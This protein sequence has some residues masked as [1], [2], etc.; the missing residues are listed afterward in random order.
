MKIIFKN[1]LATVESFLR[2]DATDIRTYQ[3]PDKD[4]TVAGI[5]DITKAQVGLDQVD[6]TSDINKPVS[7]AQQAAI[8]SAVVG[9]MDYRGVFDASVNAYP[10]SGGSG[11]AG[12]ILKSDFWIVSVLGTLPT[13][14]VVAPGD[15]IIAIVDTP[16]NTQANWS[17]VEYN[18]GFTPENAVNKDIDSTFAANSDVKYP[19]Q[20]AVKTALDLKAN[21]PTFSAYVPTLTGFSGTPTIFVARY[22]TIG[23]MCFLYIVFSGTSNATTLTFTLPIQSANT[24]AQTSINLVFNNSVNVSGLCVIRVNSTI[25]DVYSTVA[26]GAFTAANTKGLQ[27]FLIYETI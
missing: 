21:L 8:N 20:K 5:D 27:G 11:T 10:S 26:A 24:L 3:F 6:N 17:L 4:I 7:T 19:S 25:A 23:K 9:L 13:G 16:G 18:I 1:F 22:T 2:N 14:L 12:A 15:L